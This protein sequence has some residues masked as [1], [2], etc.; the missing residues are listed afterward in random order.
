MTSPG[1]AVSAY[2]THLNR[3]DLPLQVEGVVEDA[4]GIQATV[5]QTLHN[6]PVAAIAW[7]ADANTL[8]SGGVDGA[9]LTV[10]RAA[11]QSGAAAEQ[12]QAVRAGTPYA[13]VAGLCWAAGGALAS[14]G[15]EGAVQVWDVRHKGKTQRPMTQSPMEWGLGRE[16]LDV[17]AHPGRPQA[18]IV[19]EVGGASLW[20]LRK[21]A[22]PVAAVAPGQLRSDVALRFDARRVGQCEAPLL[23][24]TGQGQLCEVNLGAPGCAVRELAGESAAFVALDVEPTQGNMAFSATDFASL[25][26]VDRSRGTGF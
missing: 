25:T 12:A 11:V 7:G 5:G 3:Q 17:V 21:L 9:I 14:V 2:D 4:E 8:A 20:D 13:S 23:A 6:G 18:C 15:T 10:P 1:R 26:V 19:A 22:Q 16:L 24:A